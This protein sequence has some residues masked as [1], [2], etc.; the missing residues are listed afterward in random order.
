MLIYIV[1]LLCN[2]QGMGRQQKEDVDWTL[3]LIAIEQS[4][5]RVCVLHLENPVVEKIVRAILQDGL[6]AF[7]RCN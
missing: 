7:G 6:V 2:S 4:V 3:A 5:P 1:G